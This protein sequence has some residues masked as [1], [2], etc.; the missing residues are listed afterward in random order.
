V[1]VH[2]VDPALLLATGINQ[3]DPLV[4]TP[5]QP[6]LYLDRH[7]MLSAVGLL[8]EIDPDAARALLGVALAPLGEVRHAD[9]E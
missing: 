8:S 7:Y 3:G 6:K 5:R 1:L 2:A 4:L 9:G